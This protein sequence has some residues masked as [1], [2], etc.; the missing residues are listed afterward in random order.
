MLPWIRFIFSSRAEQN[1]NDNINNNKHYRL[2]HIKRDRMKTYYL[3]RIIYWLHQIICV[4]HAPLYWAFN[5]IFIESNQNKTKQ[6]KTKIV[7]LCRKP[8]TTTHHQMFDFSSVL[9]IWDQNG[10]MIM[11]MICLKLFK[12]FNKIAPFVLFD[13]KSFK[14]FDPCSNN[15]KHI[16]FCVSFVWKAL[17]L[18]CTFEKK[19][20]CHKIDLLLWWTWR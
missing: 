5:N 11:K 18:Q 8:N 3:L 15:S 7:A 10:S 2:T 6:S 16:T 9:L 19:M 13:I 14:H 12:N 1:N 17:N 4:L 20:Y